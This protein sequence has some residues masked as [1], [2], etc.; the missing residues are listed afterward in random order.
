MA[1]SS[2]SVSPDS[3]ERDRDSNAESPRESAAAAFESKV[4]ESLKA[5]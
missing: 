3:S 2:V 1:S 5:A 4:G